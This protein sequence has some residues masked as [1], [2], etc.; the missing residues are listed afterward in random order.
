MKVKKRI[1]SLIV[2]A[3]V[4]LPF[5][6]D[7]RAPWTDSPNP[8]IT[9]IAID[10]NDAHNVIVQFMLETPRDNSGADSGIVEMTDKNGSKKTVELGKTRKAAKSAMFTPPASGTYTFKVYGI[11]NDE[12]V[13]HESAAVDFTFTLPLEKPVI[14]ALNQGNGTVSVIWDAVKE[15]T[16]YTLTYT[17]ASGTKVSKEVSSTEAHITGLRAGSF[18]DISVT[19]LRGTESVIS[20]TLHKKINAEAERVWNFTWFGQSSN[21]ELNTL[22]MIDP[23]D[24]KFSLN[25]CDYNKDTGAINK[26]GGKFTA[27]HDGISYYYTV[28]DP[29]KE[30]FEFTATVHIDYI[31]QSPDGQEGFGLIAM[32]SLGQDKVNSKNHYTNSAAILSW[33]FTTHVNGTKKEIKDG[34]GARFVSGITRDVIEMGDSGIAQFGKSEAKAFSYDQG[35]DTVKT[36]DTYRITLKKDNTGYHAI[37]KKEYASDDTI[38]EYIMY[39]T[40]NTKLRQLDKDHIYVGFAVARGMNATFSDVVFTVTDPKNDPPALEE[41]PELIPLTHVV[42]CPTSYYSTKYPFVYTT[43]ADGHIT[44]TDKKGRVLIHNAPVKANVDFIK[45]IHLQKNMNDLTITFTPDSTYKPGTHQVIAQYNATKGDYEENYKSVTDVQSVI[46]KGYKGSKLYVDQNGDA[47]GKGTKESPLDL[48]TAM[49]Y[50]KPGQKIVL[51]G[52]TY[53]MQS[54]IVIDRG[55]NGTPL[56]RKKLTTEDNERAILDFSN[57]KSG[58]VLWGNYWEIENIDITKTFGNIKGMQVGG[59]YNIIRNVKTYDNGDTGLQVSGSSVD[60]QA[61]WPRKNLI[62]SCESYNNCDPAMNNADGFAAKLTCRDGNVFRYCIAYS[63]IDDGWDL[64]SK[65]E[66]G[67]I[68][69]VLIDQCIAYR[70]GSRLDGSGNGDGNGFK[71]GGDGIAVKHVLRNSIAY[72]NGAAGI[73]SNSNPALQ[74]E[75]VTS[76]GNKGTNIT[77]YG[78]GTNSPRDFSAK[79]VISLKAEGADNIVE[80]PTLLSESTYFFDGS[81]AKNSKDEILNDTIFENTDTSVRPTLTDK[82]TIDLHGLFTLNSNAPMNAGAIIK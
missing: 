20:D 27:F 32:D 77:L 78:K 58:F 55:N 73:T 7:E 19:A 25:S 46:V 38:T 16:G 8:Q 76:Y 67:P 56:F 61:K 18:T 54:G 75:N 26:K 52:G 49:Y 70:N 71:M 45:K 11:R 40:D 69:E 41:P 17:D 3:L 29:E 74:L 13:K 6:A 66:T 43:N 80:Q 4:S 34:V 51:K 36:G 24:L 10:S 72:E 53:Y 12:T 81:N 62:I 48:I 28:L 9:G 23:N 15:A 82:G 42:N 44:V 37:Y 30:N 65:I 57:A 33:K 5:F 14:S 39:D 64:F 35:S 50:V 63:N 1:L 47:F 68:G 60:G 31:N 2:A 79:G 21:S 59:S 22:K